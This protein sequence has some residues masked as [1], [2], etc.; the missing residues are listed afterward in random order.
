MAN[1]IVYNVG[2]LRFACIDGAVEIQ[3]IVV[4]AIDRSG[5]GVWRLAIGPEYIECNSKTARA[6][7]RKCHKS[8]KKAAKEQIKI[9]EEAIVK[10]KELTDAQD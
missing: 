3:P 5:E 7:L 10:L 8:K 2:D 9:L 6:F 4:M 1:K